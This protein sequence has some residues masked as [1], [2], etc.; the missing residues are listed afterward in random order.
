MPII[1]GKSKK[2][3]SDN[4]S[5]EMQAGKPQKQSIAIAYNV[6][7]KAKKMAYGGAAEDDME[8]GVP[9]RKPDDRRLDPT[10]Y[11]SKQMA[12]GPDPKRK[13]DDMRLAEDEYMANHFADGGMTNQQ[14]PDT[15]KDSSQRLK[16]N[17]GHDLAPA[18]DDSAA[19][20]AA[21]QEK[22]KR[23]AM[24][25]PVSSYADGGQIGGMSDG[26]RASSIA[27]AIM[28]KRKAKMMAEGGM[29]D[30]QENGEEEGS[31][32]YDDL[33]AKAAEDDLY[34]DAQLSSQPEDSNEHDVHISSDAHDMIDQ[35][36]SK[37]RAKRGA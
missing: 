34:D 29:A 28:R 12:S 19:R 10:D 30:V 8:P 24:G 37:L 3:M 23:M 21:Y 20:E 2:A 9:Q 7:R 26:D 31:N 4:I 27:D 14:D 17:N 36:R 13:P 1:H 33:N 32:P 16:I 18:Q 22:L 15:I 11:M 6:Q 25:G 5:T 35:I